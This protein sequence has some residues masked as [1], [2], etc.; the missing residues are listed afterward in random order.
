MM[1]EVQIKLGFVLAGIQN[2]LGGTTFECYISEYLRTVVYRLPEVFPQNG[3]ALVSVIQEESDF[4]V[5]MV[6]DPTSYLKDDNF[7]DQYDMDES[8]ARAMIEKF[9]NDAVS[10]TDDIFIVIQIKE[11]MNLFPAVDGQCI[12]T[13]SDGTE[14]LLIVDCD[15]VNPPRLIDRTGVINTTMAAIK[16]EFGIA[17]GVGTILDSGCFVTDDDKC[18]FWF[19]PSL[20]SPHI[21][22]SSPLTHKEFT[23]K[24]EASIDTLRQLKAE[25]DSGRTGGKRRW[26]SEYGDRLKDLI[27]ALQLDPSLDDAYLRLWF[28]RLCHAAEEF[29]KTCGW[30]FRNEMKDVKHYRDQV[31]HP[32]VERVD[33]A[34][35][36]SFQKRL[37][38]IIKSRIE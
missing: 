23:A 16:M 9:G 6:T 25:V 11:D 28:L 10:S 15:D 3:E 18:L 33:I 36:E 31:A 19:R 20:S 1:R 27:E 8:F 4:K 5:S 38:P 37:Y 30:Q 12:R 34:L 24:V 13:E 29:G 35:L 22:V 2:L 21:T 17:A 26:R 32:V 7:S 14:V